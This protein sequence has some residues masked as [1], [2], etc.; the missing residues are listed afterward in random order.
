M[1]LHFPIKRFGKVLALVV[2]LLFAFHVT[3]ILLHNSLDNRFSGLL[4]EKFSFDLER[5]FPTFFSALLLFISSL[6]FF[7]ISWAKKN[8]VAKQGFRYWSGLG[9]IFLFLSTDE[10]AHIHEHF[11]TELIWGA[12]QTSGL[13]AWPWVIVYGVFVSLFVAGYFKFWLHLPLQFKLRYFF[14]GFTYV[15]SALGFEMLEALEYSTNESTYTA[16]YLVYSSI[17]EL[18]E[19][20]AIAFLVCT[21]M[22]YLASTFPSVVFG[23]IHQNRSTEAAEHI[24]PGTT[25]KEL[26]TENTHNPTY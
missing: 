2:G 13:L 9:V 23:F 8:S 1:I 24:V 20:S 11:D 3:S 15:G 26:N 5:N 19:M 14:A 16:K 12:Y 10:A 6:L 4:V 17:E 7:L 18:F 22:R 25:P 21:N